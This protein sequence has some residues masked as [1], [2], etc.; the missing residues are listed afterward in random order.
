MACCP[1]GEASQLEDF[2]SGE[3][4]ARV[5]LWIKFYHVVSIDQARVALNSNNQRSLIVE[6]K[7][8]ATVGRRVSIHRAR[9]VE[10]LA[11]AAAYVA[12]PFFLA[13]H[14]WR[15]TGDFPKP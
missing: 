1:S 14:V 5:L 6:A 8:R 13:E 2:R 10:R 11:H 9:G 12:I 7:P 3:L 15:L 4:C